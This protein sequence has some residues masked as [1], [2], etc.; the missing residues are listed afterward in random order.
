ML[1]CGFFNSKDGDRLYN[2]D[3]INTFFE[4]LIPANGVFEG[5][6][7]VTAGDG[8]SVNVGLGKAMVNS[9]W[10]KNK[11][12]ENI[13][14]SDSHPLLYR[15]D[16][17]VLR[18]SR[19]DRNVTLILKEGEPASSTDAV[20]ADLIRSE[21]LWEICLAYITV[22]PK[23]AS[24]TVGNIT[25]CRYDTEKCGIITGLIEQV[26]TT[27]LYRQYEKQM[28]DWQNRMKNKF[29]EWM[30]TL[31]SE[32]QVNTYI[33]EYWRTYNGMEGAQSLYYALPTQYEQGDI[34]DVFLNNI[35]LMP[36]VDY[37][38]EGNEIKRD[39]ILKEGN[40]LSI[41]ILKSKVGVNPNS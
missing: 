36:D 8:M 4:G 41:R 6:F 13:I 18:W 26:D 2:A 40:T 39:A 16:S 22:T 35:I 38:I 33:G 1:S 27:T 10:I 3:D 11:S 37:T 7:Y 32:L 28:K 24:I 34:V 21:S 29:D 31:A 17:I 14:L 20:P 12:I 19:Q 9:C 5:G 23:L 15:V 25:D 30:E